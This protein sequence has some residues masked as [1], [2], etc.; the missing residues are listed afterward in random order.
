MVDDINNLFENSKIKDA[1][2]GDALSNLKNW[3]FWVE[4]LFYC[5]TL[6]TIIYIFSIP[7]GIAKDSVDRS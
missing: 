4:P 7:V 3:N 1:F 2:S 6:L 5:V